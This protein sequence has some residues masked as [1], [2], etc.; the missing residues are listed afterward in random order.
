MR[1]ASR[2]RRYFRLVD[3]VEVG[4]ERGV[5]AVTGREEVMWEKWDAEGWGDALGGGEGVG[6]EEGE[7]DC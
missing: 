3:V 2:N 4:D 1:A 6:G 5:S 7:V